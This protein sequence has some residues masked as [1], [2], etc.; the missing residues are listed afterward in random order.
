MFIEKTAHSLYNQADIA[1]IL[2]FLL[3]SAAFL[4]YPLKSMAEALTYL[5]LKLAESISTVDFTIRVTYMVY[6]Y[7]FKIKID[8]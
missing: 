7:I 5:I 1:S 2:I 4:I 6:I 8:N 3:S